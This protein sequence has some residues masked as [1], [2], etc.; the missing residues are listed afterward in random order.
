MKEKININTL[1][2][3]MDKV[4]E[5]KKELDDIN[6]AYEFALKCHQ[7]K[8]LKNGEDYITHPLNVAYILV[9]LNVDAKTIVAA[10]LHETINHGTGSLE[11]IENKFGKD[12]ANIVNS[13][14][15]IKLLLSF[16]NSITINTLSLFNFNI[17]FNKGIVSL[18]LFI[19][20]SFI[21]I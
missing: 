11:E 5:A 15:K 17:S 13:L 10:L 6:R 21:S 2:K 19:F 18:V 1:L 3:K 14:S 12:I 7:N 20:K 8:K 4:V 16:F 9:D